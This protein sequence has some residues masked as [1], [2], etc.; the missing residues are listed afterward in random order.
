[1]N[2]P[3]GY[4]QTAQI[5]V[6]MVGRYKP[7]GPEFV[8]PLREVAIIASIAD[9][10][11]SLARNHIARDLVATLIAECIQRGLADV[12]TVMMLRIA[13]EHNHVPFK[14]VPFDELGIAVQRGRE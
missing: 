2:A 8:M 12:P 7:F 6:D 3:D 13:L 10:G 4:E 9:V 11:A 14:E 5:T 1:M